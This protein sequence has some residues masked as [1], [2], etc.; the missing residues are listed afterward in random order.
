MHVSAIYEFTKNR[1][2]NL[3]VSAISE[4]TKNR[5]N[6]LVMSHSAER[7][8]KEIINDVCKTV[9]KKPAVVCSKTLAGIRLIWLKQTH[10]IT[11]SSPSGFNQNNRLVQNLLSYDIT[12][13]LKIK[14]H[15]SSFTGITT[16]YG[17]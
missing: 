12:K 16:H 15:S 7:N 10:E 4:F 14:V 8:I 9:L 11:A 2:N 17:F 5:I 1:I 13:N 6:N 3:V